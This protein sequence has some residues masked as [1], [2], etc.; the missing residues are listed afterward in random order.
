MFLTYIVPEG[1]EGHVQQ[2]LLLECSPCHVALA[3]L[4]VA[5]EFSWHYYSAGKFTYGY[6]VGF[7]QYS[8]RYCILQIS[9]MILGKG[10]IRIFG[11]LQTGNTINYGHQRLQSSQCCPF[12]RGST[13]DITEKTLSSLTR[14]G[15]NDLC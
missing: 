12:P 14:Q 10:H 13:M 3:E 8:N 7:H 9:T 6:G 11:T 4:F 15:F 2:G 1:A 5:V